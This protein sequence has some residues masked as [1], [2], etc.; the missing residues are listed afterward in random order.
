MHVYAYIRYM[1]VHLVSRSCVVG[2]KRLSVRECQNPKV[3]LVSANKQH[4][5]P[6]STQ[7]DVYLPAFLDTHDLKMHSMLNCMLTF[8]YE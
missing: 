2:D 6:C 4:F 5:L 8:L 3:C 7:R 1:Y